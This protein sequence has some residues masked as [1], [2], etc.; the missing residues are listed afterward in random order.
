[1]TNTEK[2]QVTY[3][4]LILDPKETEVFFAAKEISGIKGNS[5]FIRHLI[6]QYARSN[7]DGV[8]S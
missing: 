2:T 4:N 7:N 5:D 8:C 1:M 3:I 6:T